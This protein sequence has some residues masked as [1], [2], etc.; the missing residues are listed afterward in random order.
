MCTHPEQYAK[1]TGFAHATDATAIAEPADRSF[2][3]V[4][5]VQ[6]GDFEHIGI[7][8]VKCGCNRMRKKNKTNLR[9]IDFWPVLVQVGVANV[10]PVYRDRHGPAMRSTLL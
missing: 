2:R 4:F 5:D 10:R 7:S 3:R 8:V 9:E 1:R 6:H